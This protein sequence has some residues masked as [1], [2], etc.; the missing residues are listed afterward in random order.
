[1]QPNVFEDLLGVLAEE[2][3]LD[4]QSVRTEALRLYLDV[5][6]SL[7]LEGSLL[8]W[9]KGRISLTEGAG[10]A[11]LT[12]PEFKQ[13]L[14]GRGISRETASEAPQPITDTLA[15]WLGSFRANGRIVG[16][17]VTPATDES[18]WE[19]LQK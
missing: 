15:S 3:R 8:L 18:A 7:K 17:I 9:R 6:P 12:V 5:N 11:G 4:M 14:E 1:M 13:V 19:A 16:D 2:H 10:I